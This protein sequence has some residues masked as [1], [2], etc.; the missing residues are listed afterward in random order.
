M[1]KQVSL[2]I[3]NTR[4]NLT[5]GIVDLLCA[6]MIL[7]ITI[8]DCLVNLFSFIP[9]NSLLYC[10]AVALL[11]FGLNRLNFSYWGLV[12]S[13][14]VLAAMSIVLSGNYLQSQY[15]ETIFFGRTSFISLWIYGVSFSMISNPN[16]I[17]NYI[18]KIAYLNEVLLI[19]TVMSDKYTSDGRAINYVGLGISSVVWVSVIIQTAF[20]CRK[21]T[22]WIHAISGLVFYLFVVI[23]GNRGSIIAISVFFLYCLINYTNLN[24][25]LILSFFVLVS[26]AAIGYYEKEI[27]IVLSS[28]INYF[29]IFSRNY[30]LFLDGFIT[31]TTH[32]T[33]EIWIRCLSYASNRWFFGYGFGF[34]R[35]MNGDIDIYAHNL[36]LELWLIFGIIPGSLLFL[37][38]LFIG[39]KM[40]FKINN[41]VWSNL[42]APF[43]IT[44]TVVLMFNS[45]LCRLGIFW[46][47]YGIYFAYKKSNRTRKVQESFQL[48]SIISNTTD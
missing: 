42:F 6:S 3:Y 45:S 26:I 9:Y 38:H 44:S 33:D 4:Y 30:N 41:S 8:K 17:L 28:I 34:D 22:R 11:I 47:S 31:Y 14:L 39:Y 5:N 23:Y 15:I 46:A 16:I 40:C 12:L 10:A 48:K 36:I 37:I 20:T 32:R 19:I 24:R 7:L 27:R 18:I 35:A 13:V 43:Y 2:T 21:K 1:R 25:K 29:G